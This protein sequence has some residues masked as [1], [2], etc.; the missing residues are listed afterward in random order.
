[1]AVDGGLCHGPWG[2]GRLWR[3]PF[4]DG[5]WSSVALAVRGWVVVVHGHSI[6]MSGGS[7]S[8]MGGSSATAQCGWVAVVCGW[9]V[10]VACRLWVVVFVLGGVAFI[11]VRA[12]AIVC[13]QS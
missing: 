11:C 6:F 4:V 8:S 2:C 10:R 3:S 9:V 12:V 7:W 5:S 1:M 13:G